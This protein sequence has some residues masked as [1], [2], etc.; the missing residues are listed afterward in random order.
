MLKVKTIFLTF[1]IL[2]IS[3]FLKA[4]NPLQ[5]QEVLFSKKLKEDRTIT[6]QLP[7]SYA[8]NKNKKYWNTE[9]VKWK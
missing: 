3:P 2:I 6:V 4:A 8:N 1:I 5:H 9:G 7:K